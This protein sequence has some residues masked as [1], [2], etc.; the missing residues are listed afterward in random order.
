MT[1]RVGGLIKVDNSVLEIL[2][3]GSLERAEPVRDRGVVGA[4]DIEFVIV[5]RF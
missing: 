2:L 4:L 1:G 3:D 5:L